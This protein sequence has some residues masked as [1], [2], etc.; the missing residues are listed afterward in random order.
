MPCDHGGERVGIEEVYDADE[1]DAWR[2]AD[3]ATLSD[4]DL[5][6]LV[7]MTPR[8]EQDRVIADAASIELGLRADGGES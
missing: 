7:E 4:A 3:V 1:W 6:K 8:T 5:M 2:T